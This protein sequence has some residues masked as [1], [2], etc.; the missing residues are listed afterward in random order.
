MQHGVK[1]EDY[2]AKQKEA[3]EETKRLRIKARIDALRTKEAH[4]Q[5]QV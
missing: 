5:Q 4:I 3:K 2:K 1:R